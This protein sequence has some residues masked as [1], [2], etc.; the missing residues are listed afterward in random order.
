MKNDYKLY[1]RSLL[2]IIQI[3]CKTASINSGELGR[4]RDANPREEGGPDTFVF[5]RAGC[6]AHWNWN[7][8]ITFD[9]WYG[10]KEEMDRSPSGMTHGYPRTG[11]SCP[12]P[13]IS[14]FI[15]SV[16]SR[17]KNV[18][19]TGILNGWK[20]VVLARLAA[21]VSQDFHGEIEARYWR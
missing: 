10:Y 15:R 4:K 17:R 3:A 1:Q 16:L 5:F 13:S 12:P 2:R 21:F 18:E 14:F 19:A 11:I 8:L 6:C 7:G 20:E 9:F